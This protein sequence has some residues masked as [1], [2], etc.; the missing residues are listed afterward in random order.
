MKKRYVLIL[1]GGVGTRMGNI[2]PK[3]F[4]E[5]SGKPILFHTIDLFRSLSFPVEIIVVM[6]SDSKE[7]WKALSYDYYQ[8]FRYILTSGGISRFHSVKNGLKYV[9][10]DGGI[11]AIHDGVRP[12]V[13]KKIVEKLFEEADKKDAVIPGIKC[14]DSLRMTTESGA[15][16]AVNRDNYIAVQTPQVFTSELL[17]D[18]Y[19][20]PFSDNFTDDA[21]VVECS[22]NRVFLVSGNRENIK[23]TTPEDLIIANAFLNN[24]IPNLFDN[25][26]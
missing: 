19:G 2:V 21:S 8:D 12:L 3:Q 14:T 22:G 5:L 23:I 10:R 7:Y 6:N 1:A 4:M 24:R 13:S 9:E 26:S 25:Y 11:V 16:I 17:K 18:A 20:Q 15:T